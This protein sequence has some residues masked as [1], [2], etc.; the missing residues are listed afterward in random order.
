MAVRWDCTFAVGAGCRSPRLQSRRVRSLGQSR[1]GPEANR[2]RH[3]ESQLG[4]PISLRGHG[5]QQMGQD[6]F[7]ITAPGSCNL[8]AS[9]GELHHRWRERTRVSSETAMGHRSTFAKISSGS[10]R[11]VGAN[12]S[13]KPVPELRHVAGSLLGGSVAPITRGDRSIAQHAP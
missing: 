5:A 13:T 6:P 11:D 12:R 8:R 1:S 2:D 7:G 9:A 3:A 10:K 4:A